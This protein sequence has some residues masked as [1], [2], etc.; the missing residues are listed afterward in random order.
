MLLPPC[1][2]ADDS[3]SIDFHDV[4]VAFHQWENIS[5]RA[6]EVTTWDY[7]WAAWKHRPFYPHHSAFSPLSRLTAK[8]TKRRKSEKTFGF[9]S[10]GGSPFPLA[11]FS[12]GGGGV[13]PENMLSP[14]DD[15]IWV[16]KL[17]NETRLPPG[18][19]V[20]AMILVAEGSISSDDKK[21]AVSSSGLVLVI[22]RNESS[23]PFCSVFGVPLRS[24]ICEGP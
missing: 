14:P 13:T 20:V 4:S 11:S 3:R 17:G 9:F 15:E 16:T 22:V 18:L 1:R 12:A 7:H 23:N 2:L 21:D 19:E 5:T 10:P 24:R 8:L 6:R